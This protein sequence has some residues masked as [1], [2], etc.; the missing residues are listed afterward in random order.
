[1]ETIMA[2]KKDRKPYWTLCHHSR[3]AN[4]TKSRKTI[5]DGRISKYCLMKKRTHTQNI[6][7][8]YFAVE[9]YTCIML[10]LKYFDVSFNTHIYLFL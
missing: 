4:D 2:L 8:S 5:F 1:M 9:N 6:K 7:Y 10:T 3:L